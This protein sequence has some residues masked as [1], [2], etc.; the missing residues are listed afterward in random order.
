MSDLITTKRLMASGSGMADRAAA[1]I[2]AGLV[3]LIPTG[4]S[5]D[6]EVKNLKAFEYYDNGKVS[7]C[8]LYDSA[9]GKLKG[10]AY[11]G[12]DGSIQKIEKF[13]EN[14]DMVE[15]ALYDASGKLK[16]G[17]DGWAAMRWRYL[18]RHLMLQISYDE[19]GKPLERKYYS[20]SGKLV[21]R[22]YRDDDTVN[23]Y[24]NA[25]MYMMLGGGNIGYYDPRESYDEVNDLMKD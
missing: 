8:T 24:V 20:E 13:N 19:Y 12:A 3:L 5:A 18:D 4:A 10:K 14:G 17:I 6:G 22:L 16:A 11:C 23:P 9:T 21:M 25:A 7:K 15:E 1:L 2:L